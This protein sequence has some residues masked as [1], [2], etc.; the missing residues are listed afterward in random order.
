MN[1]GQ[2]NID[3]NLIYVVDESN[4]VQERLDITLEAIDNSKMQ[5]F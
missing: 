3:D 2:A 5:T 4:K 1:V